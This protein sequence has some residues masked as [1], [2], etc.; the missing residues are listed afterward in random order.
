MA[1]AAPA[2]ERLLRRAATDLPELDRDVAAELP[3]CYR[4][5]PAAAPCRRTVLNALGAADAVAG[6]SSDLGFVARLIQDAAAAD[7]A[8]PLARGGDGG[9]CGA[10][11]RLCERVARCLRAGNADCAAAE[12]AARLAAAAAAAGSGVDAAADR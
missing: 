8:A 6:H 11:I 7:W 12:E 10:A 4:R 2:V 1:L 3:R 5:L 9:G